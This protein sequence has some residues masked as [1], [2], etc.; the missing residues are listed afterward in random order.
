M[1]TGAPDRALRARVLARLE[2]APRRP[3]WIAAPAAAAATIALAIAL[4][5]FRH[6]SYR[7]ATTTS[8]PPVETAADSSP[9]T[10]AA[11]IKPAKAHVDA[12]QARDAGTERAAAQ[13]AVPIRTASASEVAVLAPPPLVVESIAV[14]PIDTGDSMQLSGLDVPAPLDVAPLSIPDPQ[15]EFHP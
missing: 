11:S 4:F 8:V 12:Q 2:S 15:K 7:P 10:D 5:S 3:M 9:R 1:T 6:Q 14:E 13:E